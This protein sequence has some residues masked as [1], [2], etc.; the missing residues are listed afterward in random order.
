MSSAFSWEAGLARDAPEVLALSQDVFLA[1]ILV[2]VVAELPYAAVVVPAKEAAMVVAE[3]AST[4]AEA[5][6]TVVKGS[7]Y[8]LLSTLIHAVIIICNLN[9][10]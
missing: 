5:A 3:A 6:S 10:C 7:F 1:V 2:K 9:H 8:Q 4:T